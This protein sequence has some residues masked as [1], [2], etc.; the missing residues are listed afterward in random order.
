[1]PANTL[2]TTDNFGK[3]ID[4]FLVMSRNAKAG[5]LSHEQEDA[6]RQNSIIYYFYII[7][8]C[9]IDLVLKSIITIT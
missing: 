2:C 8:L 1:V 4:S 5:G 3:K 6:H 9:N 7:Y